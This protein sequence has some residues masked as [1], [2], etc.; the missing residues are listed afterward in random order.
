[1]FIFVTV[2][3]LLVTALVLLILRF[4]LPDFRFSWLIATGGGLLAW[5]SVFVWQTGMPLLAQLPLWQ[6]ATLF[7][8]SPLFVADGIAWAFALSLTTVCIGVI[9]TAVARENFPYPISWIGVLILTALGILAV[10]ADNPL[11]LV[12][13]WA[14]IDL[15]ELISQTRLVE[16]PKLSERVVIA[17]GSR[18]TG[19]LILL[20][21]NMV[22]AA[23]GV[24]LDFL[25]A[26]PQIGLYLVAAA[27]FRMG[28]L[29]IH[30]PY[31]SESAI[32]RGFGTGLRMI[33]AGSSLI[34]LTRIP[35]D[36]V[37]S[38]VTPYLMLL[39]SIAALYSGWMWLRAPD[40]LTGRPF[41]LIGLGSLAVA[42][43]LRG[44]PIGAA[45]W[46]CALIL[47]GAALFLSSAQNTWT[48]RAL[49]IGVWGISS[50]P[51]SLTATGW[52]SQVST[53]W[54]ALPLL[55][56]SQAMLMAGFVKQIRRPSSRSTFENQPL[57]AKNAYPIGIFLFLMILLLLGLIGWSGVL[58]IGNLIPGIVASLLTVGLVWLTPRLRILNPVRAHWVQ[59]TRQ[60][61]LDMGYQVL[62]N[63]YRQLGRAGNTLSNVLEG[64]SGIMWTLL[65]L[66]LFISFFVK[67]TP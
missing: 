15:A 11:T 32:R 30:L 39:V 22:S 10:T 65:F 63:L 48:V 14:A 47:A 36:S 66:A 51:L 54:Y 44:N 37:T 64:E 53:F 4:V 56:A 52:L 40:E 35:P 7:P 43:A 16:D 6:P 20:W 38:P 12:L 1:M 21:A 23:N 9:I 45:A 26:P 57:W 19:T 41:W 25:S 59:P 33:S 29:P 5:V 61:W 24:E 42:A 60:T 50:L 34:L 13:I 62:W 27:G 31:T 58:Q 28:V 55:I 67:G 18:V 3:I 8:Q 17:F 46:S 2:S 49:Y